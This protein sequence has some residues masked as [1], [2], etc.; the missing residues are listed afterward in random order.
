MAQTALWQI[1]NDRPLKI[2][3]GR[4]DFEKQ[5]EDWI[6]ADPSLLEAGLTVVGRQVHTQGGPLDL[7]A[8][9]PQGRWIVIELKRGTVYRDTIAQAIDYAAC[10]ADMSRS[11]LAEVGR[12]Y[13]VSRDEGDSADDLLGD[14]A[15]EEDEPVEV[16]IIVAGTG[17]DPGLSRV[18]SFL[19]PAVPVTVVSFQAHTLTDGQ[20]ILVRDMTEAEASLVTEHTRKPP[21]EDELFARADEQGIGSFF[22]AIADGATR[23]GLHLRP[24]KKSLMVAPSA[25]RAR[26]LFTIWTGPD[27]EGRISAWIGTEPISE[28]YPVDE[29]RVEAALGKQG[30]RWLDSRAV[31]A[32]VAG[33]DELFGEIEKTHGS[34]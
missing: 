21:T 25:N 13:L 22:R 18:I 33:L 11:E 4:V 19:A 12:G 1:T 16:R 9:D 30:W 14:V 28:F 7:L 32:F 6:E 5:L 29:S 34:A 10:V 2:S 8:I 31:D 26:C 20:Q 3:S 23:H 15:G 17:R 27:S 24:F